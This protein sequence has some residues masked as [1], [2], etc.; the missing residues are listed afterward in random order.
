MGKT[1]TGKLFPA[2]PLEQKQFSAAFVIGI[3]VLN[4]DHAPL[5]HGAISSGLNVLKMLAR[6]TWQA[7]LALSA[8]SMAFSLA[9]EQ[10]RELAIAQREIP[11]SSSCLRKN[12]PLGPTKGKP[13]LASSVPGFRPKNRIGWG[14][15]TPVALSAPT[16]TPRPYIGQSGHTR[17]A[18]SLEL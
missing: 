17:C 6:L 8:C 15:A 12:W 18:S 2:G 13:I 16:K 14:S 4:K 1:R 5:P 9:L 10:S 7:A 11:H 3:P